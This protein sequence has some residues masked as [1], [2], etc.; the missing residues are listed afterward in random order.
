MRHGWTPDTAGSVENTLQDVQITLPDV[1]KDVLGR[2]EVRSY[3]IEIRVGAC[4]IRRLT[5]P[6]HSYN[7]F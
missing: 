4:R 7:V 6:M 5:Y 1:S 3:R 2:I